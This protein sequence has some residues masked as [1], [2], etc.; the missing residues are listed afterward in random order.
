MIQL[1]NRM[2]L[3]GQKLVVSILEGP[4]TK[5]YLDQIGRTMVREGWAPN[6]VAAR[7]SMT[8]F[9]QWVALARESDG[10]KSYLMF[11]GPVDHAF[12]AFVL[13]TEIYQATC[14]RCFGIFIHHNP[15]DDEQAITIADRD[16]LD[17]TVKM[18]QTEYGSELH[19]HLQGWVV[20]LA[21]GK[22]TAS[23][24]SCRGCDD[25]S[26]IRQAA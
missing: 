21:A 26:A 16:G 17:Y 19:Q 15:L 6:M 20:D 5:Q 25:V 13:N 24:V 2:H 12:H 7:E 11:K 4:D 10:T 3:R 8:A 18:L 22:L 9:V 1:S 23:S 14:N